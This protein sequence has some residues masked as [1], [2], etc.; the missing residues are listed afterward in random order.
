M[1]LPDVR[2][3]A[4][5]W[6][7]TDC[8]HCDTADAPLTSVQ[9]EI[10]VLEKTLATTSLFWLARVLEKELEKHQKKPNGPKKTAKHIGAKRDGVGGESKR[11][12]T[13]SAK[14]AEM[15]ENLRVRREI[16]RVAYEE[17]KILREDLSRKGESIDK[18][19]EPHHVSGE[20]GGTSN[21]RPTR[22]GFLERVGFEETSWM[23]TRRFDGGIR[24]LEVG[25][26]NTQ[27]R[28][29][30]KEEET[31]RG[32]RD[33]NSERCQ[34]GRR[35]HGWSGW[36][37]VETACGRENSGLSYVVADPLSLTVPSWNVAGL[38][39][40]AAGIFLSQIPML[41][42]W[43]VCFCKNVSGVWME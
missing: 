17:I 28:S 14:L 30:S 9:E 38:S 37:R 32:D 36:F 3:W 31:P 21:P 5:V 34:N 43:D 6:S 26:T 18:K 12:E 27:Q 23:D 33:E 39:D 11:I 35:L 29:G 16:L 40:D 25:S 19:Q 24:Q 22:F 20:H 7:R 15:Q 13:E 4:L 10:A 8:R 1:V 2:Y 42:D 41:T